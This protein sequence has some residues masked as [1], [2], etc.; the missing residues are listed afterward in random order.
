MLLHAC[1]KLLN[2]QEVLQEMRFYSKSF[3]L[4][5]LLMSISC[6]IYGQVNIQA[7]LDSAESYVK[8]QDYLTAYLYCNQALSQLAMIENASLELQYNTYLDYVNVVNR[9]LERIYDPASR[10]LFYELEYE[11]YETIIELSYQLFQKSSKDEYITKAF[12]LAERNRNVIL[13]N[14]LRGADNVNF[15][16]VPTLLL[17]EEG[18]LISKINLYKDSIELGREIYNKVRIDV[19]EKR[20][21][22]AQLAF[23]KFQEQM[24]TD[25]E[26]YYNYKTYE[27]IEIKDLQNFLKNDEAFIEYFYGDNHI[28]AFVI[29][30]KVNRLLKLSTVQPIAKQIDLFRGYLQGDEKKFI[31]ASSTLYRQVFQPLETYLAD[32]SKITFAVDNALSYIPFDALVK[33]YSADWDYD[34][35]KLDYLIYDYQIS[36]QHSA[37]ALMTQSSYH[38]PYS[39]DEVLVIAPL[40]TDELKAAY[41]ESLPEDSLYDACAALAASGEMIKHIEGYFDTKTLTGIEANF[42]NVQDN[43]NRPVLHFASHTI[44]N[45]ELPLL[46]KIA[47]AKKDIPHLSENGYLYIKDL[48]EM[49]LNTELV[50]LGSCETG[51]GK[52]KR[53]E[54]V[55]SLAYGFQLAGAKST[56][57]SLWKVD[58][59]STIRLMKWFY[60]YLGEGLPKDEALHKAK[61]SY[62]EKA[63]EISSNPYFWSGFVLNGEIQSLRFQERKRMTRLYLPF[64]LGFF[65][66]L[67][68]FVWWRIR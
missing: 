38:R 27:P 45:D 33:N 26:T 65:G 60:K 13:L 6:G 29:T 48:Y 37:A 15:A 49:A 1:S 46:S 62:L 42:K 35:L 39:S 21:D 24:M 58:E 19:L 47:L 55:V 43:Y 64:I 28:Y 41:K 31:Q 7:S 52:F 57:F 18:K 63:S 25:Y 30:K 36:Y 17:E 59:K 67:A 54:G 2:I 8:S 32:I 66:L 53:G 16:G 44:I 68:V 10:R 12:Q 11:T 23:R 4:G 51:N 5:I 22:K 40:F 20:R 50:V 9:V 56:A 3:L 61:L 34:F 14:T